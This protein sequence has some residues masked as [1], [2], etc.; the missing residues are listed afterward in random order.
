MNAI[1]HAVQ[2][3]A[4][5]ALVLGVL[6][7][8][9]ELG[10]YVA[11]RWCGI[12]VEAFSLGFGPALKSWTDRRG[13]VWKLSLLPLGGYVK[14]HGM[15]PTSRADAAES[16]EQYRAEEAFAE[17]HVG[18]R[19]FVA[20]AGPLA[21]F[22][23]AVVLYV[24]LLMAVGR[25]VPLPVVGDISPH[26]A[27]ERAGL[28]VGDEITAVD[29]VRIDRF[30]S[31]QRIISADADRD[32]K[33][34]VARGGQTLVLPVHVT[35][36]PAPG[37]AKGK[38]GVV[39]GKAVTEPVGPLDATVEGVQQTWAVGSQI[40]AGLFALITGR[41]SA[42]GLGGVITIA[43]ISG[44]MARQGVLALVSFI[45]FLSV[46]LGLVNLLPIPVLDG[47]HLMFCAAE[48][49]RGRPVPPRAQEYGYRLGIALIA[50]VFVFASWN[51]LVREG[52]LHWVARLRG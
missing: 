37:G 17:K 41:Q 39:S 13:T 18:K 8:I 21:N 38:L 33:L 44:R 29:G 31:L 25:Q 35:A 47:G 27:A 11:A 10:H 43:D 20:F 51:D 5:F 16:G 36:E 49:V 52:A 19:A 7:S 23:L 42:D 6:V 46:N 32:I 26:S 3:L 12:G 40:L 24:G 14:M 45:A 15:S 28:K 48:A 2:T 30:T 50:C 1:I 22:L 9:H 4:S 34:S